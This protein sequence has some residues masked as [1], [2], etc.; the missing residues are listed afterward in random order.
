MTAALAIAVI[1]LS[2]YN[3]LLQREVA[4][5]GGTV[6]TLWLESQAHMQGIIALTTYL[7]DRDNLD[8]SK[9]TKNKEN[10]NGR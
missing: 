4:L 3:F 6:K 7:N 2:V 8:G 1:L 9:T 10:N 5:L